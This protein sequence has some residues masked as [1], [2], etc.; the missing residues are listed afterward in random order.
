MVASRRGGVRSGIRAVTAPVRIAS[1]AAG[2]AFA[3][4]PPLSLYVHIP[5]CIRKCPYC[6]F[7]SHE[8]REAVPEARYVD[9]LL[10]DLEQA[11]PGVWGRPIRTLFFGGGTPSLFSPESIDRFLCGARSLLP[12]TA[13]AEITLEANPGTFEQGRFAAFRAAGIDRLSIGIQSFDRG[14]LAAIGRVHDDGD[15]HRAVEIARTHFENFNLDLMY[16]LPGQSPEQALADVRT[17]VASGA[18]H[19]SAYHLTIEPNTLFHRHPPVVPDD[20]DAAAMQEAIE[21][22]LAGAGYEHYETSA[23]ARPGRRARHNLNYWGFGDYLGIGAGAHGKV[24]LRDRVRREMRF[25][26][27]R[28]YMDRA[29]AGD[30]IQTAHD[31]PVAELPFEFMMNALRLTDGFPTALF[32]ER[33]SLPLQAVLGRLDDAEKR[34]FLTRDTTNVRPTQMGQRFLNELLQLFL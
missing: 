30:A 16:A 22:T 8:A 26:H 20:D 9:A 31:V 33:T 10:A 11:L 13:D 17:A 27:P 29:L 25:K 3:S 4:L 19:I 1:H 12:L 24:S 23:F 2:I 18:P 14:M 32:T 21:A 6:D 7:N 28:E 5:W 15:A 34:G